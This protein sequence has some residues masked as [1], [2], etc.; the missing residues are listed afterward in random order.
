MLSR[1]S[2]VEVEK[3]VSWSKALPH[4]L[5]WCCWKRDKFRTL[6]HWHSWRF[7]FHS[8]SFPKISLKPQLMPTYQCQTFFSDKFSTC[9][10]N[11]L[12]KYL[13]GIVVKCL[14]K[15]W[16]K[17]GHLI[18]RIG[19]EQSHQNTP[20]STSLSQEMRVKCFWFH[21][22]NA[23]YKSRNLN[24]FNSRRSCEIKC[25]GNSCLDMIPFS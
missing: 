5:D 7:Y 17:E 3:R 19:H 8:R 4:F 23:I 11:L 12:H 24:T 21:W 20:F 10:R 25:S 22:I 13:Y 1:R 18:D 2:I 16:S 14:F 9:D 6:F 15:T